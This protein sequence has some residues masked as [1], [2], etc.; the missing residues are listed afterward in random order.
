MVTA[1][2]TAAAKKAKAAATAKAAKKAP[3]ATKRSTKAKPATAKRAPMAAPRARQRAAKVPDGGPL[4]L[5]EAR[6]LAVARQPKAMA[7][8][9]LQVAPPATPRSVAQEREKLRQAQ[10]AEVAQRVREYSQTMALLKTRGARAPAAAAAPA[11]AAKTPLAPAAPAAF[12][13]LQI[14]AE[15]DSWF[16]YPP[17]ALKGGGLVPR[18]ERRLG[19]PILN[20]AKAGDEARFMLGVEQYKVLVAHLTSGCPAGGAWD[21]LL[22][23]GGGNDI[24]DNPMAL[25][26]Q[27][28]DPG[29]PPEAH[30][31]TQRF[32][33]ALALVQAAYEDLIALRN[34]LSPTTHLVFHG[35]DYAIPDGRG[36]CFNAL[37]PWLKPAFDLR[38][39][40]SRETAFKVV[41]TMLT[42]FAKALQALAD[43]HANVS[44]INGQG[45]L[46][47]A[48]SAWHNELHP[49]ADG[50]NRHAD[51]FHQV[52]KGLFPTRVV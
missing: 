24:V 44:F 11:G 5:A 27:A 28:W 20:L 47:E 49:S 23:S 16:D 38:G 3:A 25:W 4:T 48:T 34:R 42:E 9:A 18:L 41:K 7:P 32:A 35:Y 50:Y 19:V 1:K 22:F 30:L 40:P 31:N 45:L 52:L 43:K 12:M 14:M 10:D 36:V 26:V 39:F 33:M 8:R 29:K 13:P 15:G 37:G 6:A 46:P 51:N 21:V 2:K 17:F